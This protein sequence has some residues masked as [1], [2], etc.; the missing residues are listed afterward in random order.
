MH[1]DDLARVYSTILQCATKRNK[2]VGSLFPSERSQSF[3]TASRPPLVLSVHF[4][5][6]SLGTKRE[7]SLRGFKIRRRR[8]MEF[9]SMGPPA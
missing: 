3:K 6:I 9:W 8:L 1:G 5:R 7:P 2:Y 4:S